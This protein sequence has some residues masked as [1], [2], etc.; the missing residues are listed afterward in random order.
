VE[1]ALSQN[2]G[3]LPVAQKTLDNDTF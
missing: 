1:I 3:K 2:T